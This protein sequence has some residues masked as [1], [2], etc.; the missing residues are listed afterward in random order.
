LLEF[1]KSPWAELD[2]EEQRLRE[3]PMSGLGCH[4]LHDDWYGGK[5][6]FTLRLHQKDPKEPVYTLEVCPPELG[7]STRMARRWGSWRILRVRIPEEIPKHANNS[8]NVL[9]SILKYHL[10]T[11]EQ[12]LLNSLSATS[13]FT[14]V[15][16]NHSMP[17]SI[18]FLWFKLIEPIR[19]ETFLVTIP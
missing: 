10:L 14:V 11:G 2:K 9:I 3:D 18:I 19:M 17:R 4:T 16:S 1:S 12:G 5:I 8:K 15:F 13:C 7:T 6:A